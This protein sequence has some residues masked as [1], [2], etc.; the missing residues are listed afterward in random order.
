LETDCGVV[1][2]ISSVLGVGDF[3]R[4]RAHAEI[5]EI[6]G[7]EYPVISLADLIAAKEACGREKDLLAA[8]ELR[9]IAEKRGLGQ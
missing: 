9:V 3:D 8:K 5:F 4:L 6:R 1:Y 2:I 7:R